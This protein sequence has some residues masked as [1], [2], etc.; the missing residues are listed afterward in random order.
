MIN[1]EG[2]YQLKLIE[3]MEAWGYF[4]QAHN[5][6]GMPFVPDLSFAYGGRDGWAELKWENTL[7]KRL[8]D[9]EHFTLGQ[10]RW[11]RNQ[12]AAGNGHCYVIVGTPK[13]QWAFHIADLTEKAI[14]MPFFDLVVHAV[15]C[16]VSTASMA[17]RLAEFINS[18]PVLVYRHQVRTHPAP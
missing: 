17:I 11:L 10:R 7:P 4:V 8:V 14:K 13:M 12:Y 6:V 2:E 9:I 1:S 18:S 3:A 15:A 5:D 16:S